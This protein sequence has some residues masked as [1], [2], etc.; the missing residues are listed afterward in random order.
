MWCDVS[1]SGASSR[2][3][4]LRLV[5]FLAAPD[6]RT[7]CFADTKANADGESNDYQDDQDLA[8]DLVARAQPGHGRAACALLLGVLGLLLPVVLSRPYGT[9]CGCFHSHT[10][11]AWFIERAVRIEG[12]NIGI[13]GVGCCLFGVGVGCD[14]SDGGGMCWHSI[15]AHGWGQ[16][17]VRHRNFDGDLSGED[18]TGSRLPLIE[19]RHDGE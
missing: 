6:R 12:F 16:G 17:L 13:K 8:D 7:H 1:M 14:A 11:S 9:V 18:H 5:R 2:A 15:N 19:R 3:S 10:F 4:C